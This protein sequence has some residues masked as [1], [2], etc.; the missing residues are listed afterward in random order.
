MD[1]GEHTLLEEQKEMTHPS[2]ENLKCPE[3]KGPMV[4]RT[5]RKDG[6]KFWGCKSYPKC[7]GTRDSEG[8]SKEEKRQEFEGEESEPATTIV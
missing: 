1:F 7:N 5:N 6:T 3:C 8:L 4:P 2:L